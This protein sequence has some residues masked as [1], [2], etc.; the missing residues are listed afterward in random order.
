MPD[1]HTTHGGKGVV[2]TKNLHTHSRRQTDNAK[3][4]K[5]KLGP[6]TQQCT[7]N[8]RHWPRERISSLRVSME[9]IIKNENS[10]N[11]SLNWAIK[12]V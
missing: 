10:L 7:A 4:S 1:R 8:M 5:R 11:R 3:L 12:G 6:D 2:H 9:R